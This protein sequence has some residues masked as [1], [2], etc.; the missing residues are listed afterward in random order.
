MNTPSS[1]QWIRVLLVSLLI[2]VVLIV[3]TIPIYLIVGEQI[4][5]GSVVV[6][7]F[8]VPFLITRWA[9]RKIKSRLILHGFLIGIVATLMYLGLVLAG[10]G[11][12]AAITMYGPFIFTFANGLRTLGTVLGAASEKRRRAATTP[13]VA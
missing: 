10:G 8:V 2:E 9:A 12:Q 11:M 7:V 5:V 4:F 3:V 13:A 6:L 1:I